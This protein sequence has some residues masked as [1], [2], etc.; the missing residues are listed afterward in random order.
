MCVFQIQNYQN[1]F[2]RA[3]WGGLSQTHPYLRRGGRQ[4]RK[5]SGID[6]HA[7][8]VVLLR[9]TH[10]PPQHTSKGVINLNEDFESFRFIFTTLQTLADRFP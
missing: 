8:A 7:N 1:F 3:W 10:L 9:Q 6:H 4:L 5:V 2:S